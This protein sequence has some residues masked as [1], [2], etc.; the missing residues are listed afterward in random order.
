M[1][2]EHPSCDGL[3]DDVFVYVG[4][5]ESELCEVVVVGH[6]ERNDVVVGLWWKVVGGGVVG[7]FLFGPW[8]EI[9]QYGVEDG[10]DDALG[11]VGVGLLGYVL[12]GVGGVGVVF[13]GHDVANGVACCFDVVDEFGF[14]EPDVELL[15]L[16]V[17]VA[18]FHDVFFFLLLDLYFL[19]TV[20]SLTFYC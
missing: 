4:C 15:R 6:G 3:C 16:R 11:A 18:L 2:C 14:I 1:G 20:I 13:G 5:E 8:C 17:V 10:I 7:R 12:H 9:L 19:L